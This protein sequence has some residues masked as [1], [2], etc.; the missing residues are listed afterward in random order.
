MLP[1]TELEEEVEEIQVEDILEEAEVVDLPQEAL[2]ELNKLLEDRLQS[3]R[4]LTYELWA[5][6]P[7]SSREKETN[8]KIGLTNSD[9]ITEPMQECQ[10]SSHL[11]AKL[12]WHSRSWTDQM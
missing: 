7:D 2:E 3:N 12:P 8:P 5:L 11:F 10:D 1:S 9:T 6:H 4:L